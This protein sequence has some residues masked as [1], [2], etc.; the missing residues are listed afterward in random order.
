MDGVC[1]CVCV[2]VCRRKETYSTYIHSC[3]SVPRLGMAPSL[4]REGRQRIIVRALQKKPDKCSLSSSSISDAYTHLVGSSSSSSNQTLPA[5]AHM[6]VSRSLSR[7]WWTLCDLVWS[8][9]LF[10]CLCINL[11]LGRT[12]RPAWNR[13]L[14]YHSISSR[15]SIAGL[16]GRV[17][18]WKNWSLQIRFQFSADSP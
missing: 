12:Q 7:E 6:F 1:V 8:F 10:V 13:V 5:V 2:C 15:T 3:Y 4:K 16:A 17:M 14:C 18:L 11:Y 9:F